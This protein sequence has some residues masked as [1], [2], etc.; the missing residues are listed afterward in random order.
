MRR[1][2]ALAALAVP[3][4]ACQATVRVG[5]A[6]KVNGSGDLSVALILDKQ[7]AGFVGDPAAVIKTADLEKSG[8]VADRTNGGDKPDGAI[9][10]SLHHPFRTVAEANGLLAGLAGNAPGTK[11]PFHLILRHAS[12]TLESGVSV[13]GEVDTSGGLDA[14]ADDKL[15]VALGAPTLAALLDA[16]HKGGATVP[17]FTAQVATRLP[18][19]PAHV[20][21]GGRVEGDTVVW[22][23]PLGATQS[24]GASSKVRDAVAFEWLLGAGA[25]LAAFVVVVLIS[26][27]RRNQWRFGDGHNLSPRDRRG[28]GGGGRH[29]AHQDRWSLPTGPGSR[30]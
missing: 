20:V 13:T 25:F 2:A 11:D 9:V 30:R 15:R 3:L 18:G 19:P 6:T 24:I 12:G 28:L 8:W 7:A 4:C 17:A 16:V 14:F 29:R 5:I 27:T 21:A 10:A 26:F 22:N 1:F 23:V